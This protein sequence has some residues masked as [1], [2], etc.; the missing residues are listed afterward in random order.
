MTTDTTATST[1]KEISTLRFVMVLAL[2]FLVGVMGATIG[3]YC[4]AGNCR[5]ASS[6][7][8]TDATVNVENAP[9]ILPTPTSVVPN[10]VTPVY[11]PVMNT[12]S[13]NPNLEPQQL[14][15]ACQFLNLTNTTKCQ[16]T[17]SFEGLLSRGRRFLRKSDY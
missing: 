3:G 2:I 10:T 14:K 9:P 15:V 5:S 6:N 11:T 8:G 7:N 1:Q 17:T 16:S 4:G 12:S 13:Q